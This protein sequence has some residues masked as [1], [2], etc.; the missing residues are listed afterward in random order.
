MQHTIT[1]SKDGSNTLQLTQ[2]NE[3]YHSTN[4]AYTEAMHIYINCGLEHL[5]TKTLAKH[6]DI[7]D[8]GFGTALNCILAYNW[9]QE[10]KQSGMPYPIITYWGIEKFPIPPTEA[11]ILN[12]PDI[13]AR[14]SK[15]PLQKLKEIFSRIHNSPWEEDV[16]IQE[17]S[18]TLHKSCADIATLQQEYYRQAKSPAAIFYDTF[19]PATQ[20][21]LWDKKIFRNIAQG[22]LPGSTLVTYCCKGTVKQALRS[23]GFTLERL[24]GPPG[25]RHI[26]RATL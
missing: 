21:Q 6:I 19:S 3:T 26:L 23:A 5:Y 7:F 9:Q 24:A 16:A 17:H 10:L 2:Y 14:H 20:P 8:I 22:C 11:Q 25:K 18:F 12:Y 15:T 13:I 4:G 1:T